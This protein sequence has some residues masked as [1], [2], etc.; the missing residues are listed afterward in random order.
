MTF[1]SKEKKK[2]EEKRKGETE[3]HQRLPTYLLS[4]IIKRFEIENSWPSVDF[5]Y[6]YNFRKDI[7]G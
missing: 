4:G 7:Y 2:E 5:D 1:F 6:S 3:P